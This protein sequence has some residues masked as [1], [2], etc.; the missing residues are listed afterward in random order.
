MS[1]PQSTPHPHPHPQIIADVLNTSMYILEGTTNSVCLGCVYGAISYLSEQP[2][3]LLDD[4][5]MYYTTVVGTI[6]A[7][8]WPIALATCT[9][10]HCPQASCR[11]KQHSLM[12]CEAP[13]YRLA[14]SPRPVVHR[15]VGTHCSTID[16]CCMG[17]SGPCCQIMSA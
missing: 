11:S 12:W 1:H 14:V 10:F 4:K 13:P 15:E 2:V 5:Y 6:A 17:R 7:W 9:P 8:V 16:L 3:G